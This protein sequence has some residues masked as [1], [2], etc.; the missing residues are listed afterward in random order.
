MLHYVGGF[1]AEVVWTQ[2]EELCLMALQL[3]LYGGG[4]CVEIVIK[5]STHKG[6]Q[7][8]LAPG[9]EHNLNPSRSTCLNVNEAPNRVTRMGADLSPSGAQTTLLA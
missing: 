7:P 5:L 8:L 3:V 1:P 4:P 9:P 2:V 6:K